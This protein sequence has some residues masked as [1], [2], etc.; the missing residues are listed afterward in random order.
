[1]LTVF[2]GKA[3]AGLAGD[4]ADRDIFWVSVRLN[5][6]FPP[7]LSPQ[8]IRFIFPEPLPYMDD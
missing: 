2:P 6:F 3:V 1:M 7:S 5:N 4:F 8:L